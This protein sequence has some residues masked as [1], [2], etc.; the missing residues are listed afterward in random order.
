MVADI[1]LNG[2]AP[3]F[4]DVAVALKLFIW[5]RTPWAS[6]TSPGIG[7]WPPPISPASEMG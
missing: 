1:L 3:H 6:D 4:Q 7:T 2:L 5:K